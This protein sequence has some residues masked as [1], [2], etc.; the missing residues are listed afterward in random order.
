[1]P[2]GFSLIIMGIAVIAMGMLAI[3]GVRMI[4]GGDRTKGVLMIAAA[5]VLLFNLMIWSWVP[6][7]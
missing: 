2:A 1:M 6:A 5:L 3:G 7:R 4:R